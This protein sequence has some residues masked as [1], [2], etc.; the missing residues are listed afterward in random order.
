MKSSPTLIKLRPPFILFVFL[1]FINLYILRSLYLAAC[2]V[3][4]PSSP[5]E[6]ADPTQY[7]TVSK[8]WY[9]QQWPETGSPSVKISHWALLKRYILDRKYDVAPEIFGP[10]SAKKTLSG[11]NYLKYFFN[12]PFFRF[13]L[14]GSPLLPLSEQSEQK[15]LLERSRDPYLFPAPFCDSQPMEAALQSKIGFFHALQ[16]RH[17]ELNIFIY[18]I[19]LAEFSAIYD[20]LSPGERYQLSGPSMTGRFRSALPGSINYG[21]FGYDLPK[22][23]EY[24]YRS[25]HHWNAKGAWEGYVQALKLIR[26]K[27]PDIGD[28]LVPGRFFKVDGINFRGAYA[29]TALYAGVFD[30]LWDRDVPVPAYDIYFNDHIKLPRNDREALLNGQY[31]P[32]DG[33]FANYYAVYWGLNY[34]F[35]RYT[36][37]PGKRNLLLFVDSYAT[38]MEEYFTAH[39]SNVYVIDV[40]VYVGDTMETFSLEAFLSSHHVDDVLFLMGSECLL[41][42]SK[43]CIFWDMLREK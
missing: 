24:F 25:D 31:L 5:G 17:P 28:P 21:S 9:K 18:H 26:K 29:K 39:Y 6:K 35:L 15:I 33:I 42:E 41:L 13:L 30:E 12:D 36:S 7:V 43:Q 34:G 37:S 4:G 22:F 14:P 38:C 16:K 20:E 23:R 11:Y 8:R 40:R 1:L 32:K 10:G 27:V 3:Y 2:F 19:P